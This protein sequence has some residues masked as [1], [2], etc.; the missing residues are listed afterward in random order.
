MNAQ[1]A[2]PCAASSNY[3]NMRATKRKLDDAFNRLDAAVAPKETTTAEQPPR[4][5][6]FLSQSIYSTLSKYG[7]KSKD[8][9]GS[10]TRNPTSISKNTPHL[11]AILSRAESRTR[12]TFNK[13]RTASPTPLLSSTADYR[14]S[15]I[16]SF[17]NRLST[18]KLSTYANKP[19]QIDAV[20]AAKCGWVNDG[21]DRL[22][23]GICGVSW[24][25]AGREGMSR[26]AANSLIEKQRQSLVESHKS[27]CPW[28]TRQ[29][30]DLIYRIP[31]QS[32]AATVRELKA[33]ASILE[34]I[35][36]SVEI[37]HPLTP[38]QLASL[39]STITT[40]SSPEIELLEVEEATPQ[41]T[42]VSPT[43]PSTTAVLTALFGWAPAPERPRITSLSRPNSRMPTSSSTPS[44]SRASSLAPS[45]SPQPPLLRDATNKAKA[46]D[47]SLLHCV[48]C[49]RRVGMWAFISQPPATP[50]PASSTSDPAPNQEK[51]P[52]QRQFDL[53]KEHRSYC[54]Y[55]VRSTVV[56]T[57]PSTSISTTSL[58]QPRSGSGHVRSS[59]STSQ[60]G[61]AINGPIEGWRAVL[62]VALRYRMVQRHKSSRRLRQG[63]G[64]ATG[65]E[66]EGDEV[67]ATVDGVNAMLEGVKTRGGKDLLKYVKGLLG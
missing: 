29:C 35:L 7:I 64:N 63:S 28:K 20:A 2:Q 48:L 67:D 34:P 22:V 17:L 46:R 39:Q 16:P 44:L 32:P 9:E 30:D 3:S 66:P 12:E 58:P 54:P 21:K 38:N 53:L 31:L 43:P 49:Q 6:P 45:P 23:C 40:E 5:K 42:D 51:T 41:T 27:G 26:D 15:S 47:T 4:K 10:K 24:V 18:F 60:L 62:T 61:S 50:A 33:N 25:V 19:P 13:S 14:P 37:K 8:S 1:P 55:V 65:G 56:P 59:S 52:K 57:L 36:Q 11:S